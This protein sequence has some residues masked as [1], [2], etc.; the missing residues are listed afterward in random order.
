MS[1]IKISPAATKTDIAAWTR[2]EFA[3][4]GRPLDP[5]LGDDAAVSAL[6]L[7]L[8]KD[9]DLATAMQVTVQAGTKELAQAM[10]RMLAA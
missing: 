2:A 6:V 4:H 5:R 7:Y 8:V 10:C 9:G 1:A 3:R